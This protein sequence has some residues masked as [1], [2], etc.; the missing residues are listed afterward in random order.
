MLYRAPRYIDCVA[1]NK[2]ILITLLVKLG[3]GA[4]MASALARARTF[5]RLLFAERRSRSQTVALLAFFLVPLTLGVWVRITVNNFLAADI[6]FETTILLGL[7]L[8]PGWAMLSGIVLS[9]PAVYNHEFL[10][11]PFDA[12]LG[13]AA[14]ILGRFVEK[15]EI[16]DFT[17]FIDLSLY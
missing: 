5:Q 17:P 8:G 9:A 16:W 13:L 11:L 2:L 4:A 1:D 7:L 15:E 10:A 14:G 3:V 6:S 12:A